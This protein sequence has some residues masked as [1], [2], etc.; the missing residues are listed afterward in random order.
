MT[1][2]QQTID[3]IDQADWLIDE[4]GYESVDDLWTSDPELFIALAAE[5][6]GEHPMATL[7]A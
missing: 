4:S 5:W 3:A 7:G 6:R 1:H 2:E